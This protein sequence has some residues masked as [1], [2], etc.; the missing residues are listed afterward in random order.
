MAPF[1]ARVEDIAKQKLASDSK[2]Q[3]MPEAAVHREL[4]QELDRSGVPS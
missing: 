2:L 3:Y 1:M 4:M